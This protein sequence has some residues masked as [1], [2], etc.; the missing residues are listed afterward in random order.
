MCQVLYIAGLPRADKSLFRSI[1]SFSTL[2]LLLRAVIPLCNRSHC[3]P[4]EAEGLDGSNGIR[5]HMCVLGLSH[6]CQG[7]KLGRMHG[8]ETCFKLHIAPPPRAQIAR[9]SFQNAHHI[10]EQQSASLNS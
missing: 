9:E 6:Q 1:S 2:H 7:Q 5:E 8:D 4:D 10:K 3:C